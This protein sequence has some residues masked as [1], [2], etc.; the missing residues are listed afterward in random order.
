[1]THSLVISHTPGDMAPTETMEQEA[2]SAPPRPGPSSLVSRVSEALFSAAACPVA[3]TPC[4]LL[5]LL[6]LLKQVVSLVP[7]AP[8]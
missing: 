6:L 1:M 7:V 8:S 3:S 4:V 5:F 2:S